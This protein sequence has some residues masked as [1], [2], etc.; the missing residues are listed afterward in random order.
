[1][2]RLA[3]GFLVIIALAAAAPNAHADFA[4]GVAAFRD[5]DF[6]SAYKEWRPLAERGNAAAQHNL[7]T[8]YNYGLGLDE[9]LV[10][11]AKWYGRAAR[12][13]NASAQTKMGIFLAQGL[14]LVA[15]DYSAAAAWFREAA[16]QHHPEAQYNLGVLYATGSG[17]EQDR[18]QALMWLSLAQEAGVEQAARPR[19]SLIGE[20]PPGDVEEA[21]LLAEIMRPVDIKRPVDSV[22]VEPSLAE[23]RQAPAAVPS[24]ASAS[25]PDVPAIVVQLASYVSQQAA[26][27]GWV[28]LRR[29]HGDLLGRLNY[30]IAVIDLGEQGNFYRL[31]A[32]PFDNQAMARALCAELKSRNIYCATPF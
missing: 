10:E 28:K 9:D 16:E 23:L 25:A 12:R 3:R 4:A 14:G 27:D 19:Q 26:A 15:Q 29:V 2:T 24:G 13:G 18:V 17:V 1:M 21:A 8:L 7:G 31:L 22:A 6:E 5:G 30:G 20:M 32:G 11:A